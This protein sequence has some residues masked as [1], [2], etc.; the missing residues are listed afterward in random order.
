MRRHLEKLPFLLYVFSC[1]IAFGYYYTAGYDEA[2]C[3]WPNAGYEEWRD[4]A[5]RNSAKALVW[6]I[7][8]AL[9]TSIWL[10]QA[11]NDKLCS[12]YQL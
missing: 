11:E 12:E 3:R 7:I 6:P 9:D 8:A 10:F 5:Q 4:Y 2:R 1:M